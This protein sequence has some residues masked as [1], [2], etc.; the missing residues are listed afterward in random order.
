MEAKVKAA[1]AFLDTMPLNKRFPVTS[2][3]QR[4]TIKRWMRCQQEYDGGV[5]FNADFT[6]VY[7]CEMPT[8]K[9]EK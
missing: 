8:K 5:S 4:E 2:D 3:E 7:K 6:E 9:Q 1:F